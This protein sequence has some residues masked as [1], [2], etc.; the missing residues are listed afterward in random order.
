MT[1]LAFKIVQTKR[2]VSEQLIGYRMVLAHINRAQYN[3]NTGEMVQ[4]FRACYRVTE[5]G[6]FTE[7]P[8]PERVEKFIGR[9]MSYHNFNGIVVSE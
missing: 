1:A 7:R 8:T 6:D 9:A 4:S 3:Q 2:P 5:S